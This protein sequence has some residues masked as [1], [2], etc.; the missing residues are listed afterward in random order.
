MKFVAVLIGA[1]AVAGGASAQEDEWRVTVGAGGIF[2]PAYEGDDDSRLSL[3]P[4][5]DVRYGER[6]SASV[7][8]GARYRAVD[9]PVWRVGPIARIKF[10]RD[11]DGSQAF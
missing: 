8:N 4:N 2:A 1:L 7:Q 6:F 10:S 11:E 5:I 9:T 3:V